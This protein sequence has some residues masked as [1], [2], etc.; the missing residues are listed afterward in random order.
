MLNIFK[1]E[2]CIFDVRWSP[3][4]YLFESFSFFFSL[5]SFFW[6][7]PLRLVG[8]LHLAIACGEVIHVWEV[9]SGEC[10][11]TLEGHSDW[12]TEVSW[13]SDGTRIC[14]G[15]DDDTVKVWE[16]SS[17]EC[18]RTLEGHPEDLTAVS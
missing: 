2:G 13:S 6:I 7:S 3:S 1:F 14:S 9:S 15:S 18:I 5:P 17:G 12:V 10:I 4:I 8:N 16:V 11:R